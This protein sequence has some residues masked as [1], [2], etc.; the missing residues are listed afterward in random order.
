MNTIP[1]QSIV[2]G[3]SNYSMGTMQNSQAFYN[4]VTVYKWA[5]L[6]VGNTSKNINH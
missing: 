4:T 5:T 3:H 1:M 2:D 6:R